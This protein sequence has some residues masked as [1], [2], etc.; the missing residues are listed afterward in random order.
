M[1]FVNFKGT[2]YAIATLDG[3]LML[4]QNDNIIWSF[5]V[6]HQ[7]FALRTL[8]DA[9]SDGDVLVA[10]AWDGQTYFLDQERRSVRFQFEETVC[11]FTAGEYSALPGQNSGLCLVYTT[12]SQK[13]SNNFY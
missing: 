11:G 10:C 1:Y 2:R 8:C 6:D 13:V 7:V 5:Q 12:F 9:D 3:T 4:L